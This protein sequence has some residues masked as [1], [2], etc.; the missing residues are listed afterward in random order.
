MFNLLRMDIRR[1]FRS[2][3]FYVMLGLTTVL[4]F[5]LL[6]LVAT[7][8]NPNTLDAI[9]AKLHGSASLQS[10]DARTGLGGSELIFTFCKDCGE[11]LGIKVKSPG[12]VR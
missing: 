3:N 6:L 2:R 8:S 5:L 1:L 12:S 7:I 11:V 9:Q 4:L 10:L